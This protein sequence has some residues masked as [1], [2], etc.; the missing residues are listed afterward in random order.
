[1]GNN[2]NKEDFYMHIKFIGLEIERF[3]N[4][5]RNVTT[6]KDIIKC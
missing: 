4:N 6:L 1:M 2:Y 3:Y 5:F